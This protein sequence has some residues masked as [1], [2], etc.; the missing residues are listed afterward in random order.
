L[1]LDA[2]HVHADETVRPLPSDNLIVNG[3]RSCSGDDEARREKATS[4]SFITRD[5]NDDKQEETRRRE[6]EQHLIEAKPLS[7]Q[8]LGT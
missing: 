2:S 8:A 3:S 6:E 5:D 7:L 4:S 1:F